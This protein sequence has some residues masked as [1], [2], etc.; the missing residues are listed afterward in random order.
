[1]VIMVDACLAQC[2]YR[3]R[4]YMDT[5]EAGAA[6]RCVYTWAEHLALLA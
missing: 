1:M 2:S 3:I 5:H 4:E 6:P